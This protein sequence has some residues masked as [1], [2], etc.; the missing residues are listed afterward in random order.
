MDTLELEDAYPLRG[1]DPFIETQKLV[2]ARQALVLADGRQIRL[3]SETSFQLTT[4]SGR[5]IQYGNIEH[6]E[7]EPHLIN[8][9]RKQQPQRIALVSNK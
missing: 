9:Y 7:Y 6:I 3:L 2:R 8:E 5:H 4:S 1:V